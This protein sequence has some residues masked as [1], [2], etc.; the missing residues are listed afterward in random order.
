MK[1]I[2]KGFTLIELMIVVAII[3]ILAAVAIPAYQDYIVKS[4]LSTVASSM[5][6][7]KMALAQYYQNNGSFPVS[8]ANTVTTALSG[9]ADN[10]VNPA[11]IW[12][13]IGFSTY[14]TLPTNSL[15]M[16]YVSTDGTPVNTSLTLRLDKI[17]VLTVDGVDLK[18]VPA[19]SSTAFTWAGT[20]TFGNA[21]VAGTASTSV[22]KQVKNF[23]NC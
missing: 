7:T 15:Q 20:C 19:A 22:D 8:A 3:G 5:D 13:S 10:N 9:T 14:P 12:N 1:Q 2:Q 6:S 17:R 23:F 21:G 16:V 18:L 11:D 4:K